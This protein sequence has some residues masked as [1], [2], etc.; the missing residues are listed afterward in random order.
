MLSAAI[1]LA[2]FL[3]KCCQ[4]CILTLSGTC[5]AR[6]NLSHFLCNCRVLIAA[7]SSTLEDP[8]PEVGEDLRHTITG[9]CK[10]ITG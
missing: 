10:A 5:A 2:I 3:E 1:W 7:I 9:C 4:T 8:C 6:G